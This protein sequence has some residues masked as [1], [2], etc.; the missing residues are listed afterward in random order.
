MTGEFIG[1]KIGENS[2][3]VGETI[4]AS[5]KDEDILNKLGRVL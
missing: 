2:I 5:E 3:N 1:N 4:I